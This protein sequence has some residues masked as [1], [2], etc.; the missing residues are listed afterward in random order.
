MTH[1]KT[2]SRSPEK[3]QID[4]IEAFILFFIPIFL[5]DWDN[6]FPV[7]GSLQKTFA[8]TPSTL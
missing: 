7:L 8:K 4:P 1:I 5:R 3:A 2:I 6:V